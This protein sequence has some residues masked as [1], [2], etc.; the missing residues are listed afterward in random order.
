MSLFITRNRKPSNNKTMRYLILCISL[1]ITVGSTV[2]QNTINISATSKVLVPAD[3]IAFQININA[4][5]DT[6]QQAYD[7]H[8]EREQ[9]LVKLL[10][11]HNIK[12]ENIN[13]EPISISRV[14][15]SQYGGERQDF[16]RTRQSVTLSLDD[17][18]LYEEIQLTLIENDFDEF[19]GNFRSSETESGE[20]EALK[21]ALKIAREK[22]NIIA[23]ETGLSISGIKDISYSY[24]QNGPRP[25]MEMAY[26]K[27][28][29]SLMEFNQTVSISANVSITYKTLRKGS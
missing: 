5:G 2:A 9:V 17:F 15:N 4:E 7:L 10:K 13:F 18:D 16:V 21:K 12:E 19:S 29:D 22:A 14:T 27:S 1:F 28:S 6:P 3:E 20:N 11:K 25:M 24:N 8:K 23:N 26:Q